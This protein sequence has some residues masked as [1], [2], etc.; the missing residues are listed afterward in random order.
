MTPL[1]LVPG[2]WRGGWADEGSLCRRYLTQLGFRTIVMPWSY[3]TDG[4]P[5]LT[6]FAGESGMSDWEAGGYSVRFQLCTLIARGQV[7]P[8]RIILLTHSH[9]IN[10]PIFQATLP[11]FEGVEPIPIHAVVSICAPP[12]NDMKARYQEARAGKMIGFHRAIYADGWDFMARAGQAFD[13]SWGWRRE[14]EGADENVGLKGIGHSKLL[15]DEQYLG[16][17]GAQLRGLRDV[18]PA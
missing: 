7:D 6:D 8:R 18:V 9:G 12:R 17:L 3:D 15:N 11:T 14:W 1:L 2:T 5:S 16:M 10:P 13:G 4:L